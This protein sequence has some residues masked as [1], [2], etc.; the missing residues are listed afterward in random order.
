MKPMRSSQSQTK[1]IYITA[2]KKKRK[3]KTR[4]TYL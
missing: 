1:K 3:R 4:K 2:S